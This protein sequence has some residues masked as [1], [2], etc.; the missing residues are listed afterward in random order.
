VRIVGRYVPR[1]EAQRSWDIR[2]SNDRLNRVFELNGLSYG[3]YPGVDVVDRRGKKPAAVIEDDP[4]PEAAPSTKK[5]KLGT[6]VGKLGVSENF[7]MELMGTCA[8]PG[9]RMSSP[10]LRESSARMLEVTGRRWPKNVPIPRAAGEDF[11]TSRMARNLRVF[12]YGWNIAAVVS[13]VMNKDRH[14]AAQKR[15]AV[16]RLPEAR[17]KR[18]RGSA[19]AAVPGGSQ[20]SL[21]TKLAAPGSS[22][23]PESTKAAGA[24]GTKS[25]PEGAA[26]VR[27]QPLPG[28]RV[29]DFGTNISVDD[30]LVG[31]FFLTGDTLQGRA[32]GNL[33]PSRLRWQP[34]RL[35]R[36]LGVKGGAFSAGGE[37]SAATAVKDEAGTVSRR[38]QEASLQ[39]T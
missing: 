17:P 36:F 24:G 25:A 7:A 14:D 23:L 35:P 13:V 5:R 1:T 31:K 16:V 18:A 15:R 11:F 10:E 28:K 27:E 39:L 38:L 6:A 34:R 12:P 30:Y 9:G 22:K 21:A 8:A 20:P 29:A 37:V 33:L 4:A 19:K 2:G 26:K 3:G 32:K